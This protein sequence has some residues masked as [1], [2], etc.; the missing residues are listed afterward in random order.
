MSELLERDREIAAAAAVLEQGGLLVVDGGAGTGKTSL[1]DLV[2]RHA[3]ALGRAVVRARGSELESAFPFGVARQLFERPLDDLDPQTRELVTAGPAAPAELV[4]R[5]DPRSVDDDPAFAVLHGLYWLTVNLAARRPLVVVV[6]D[7]HWSDDG[8]L[9]WLAYLATRLGDPELTVAVALRPSEPAAHDVPLLAVRGAAS[10][11]IQPPLLSEAAVAR[12]LHGALGD[13]VTP[14]LAQTIHRASGGNPLYL[15]ELVRLLEDR[16]AIAPILGGEMLP[17]VV[18]E[19]VAAQVLARARRVD[20]DALRLAQA[21]A[22]LGDGTNIRDGAALA[23]IEVTRAHHLSG[24]L[25]R[26][27]LLVTDEPVRFRHPVVRE[28]V[29][30]SLTA[31]ERDDGHRAAA[32]LLHAQGARVALVAAHLMRARPVGDPWVVARLVDAAADALVRGAPDASATLLERARAE[33]PPPDQRVACLRALATAEQHLGRA[34][35]CDHL[36]EAIRLAPTA[37]ERSQLALQLARSYAGLFRWTDAVD[38]L[39]GALVE[40]DDG[41]DV[42]VAL[43]AELVASGLQDARTASRV[44]P[45]LIRMGARALE[46]APAEAHAVA[47]GLAAVHRGLPATEVAGPLLDA[48]AR[49]TSRPANWQA[50]AAL[51]WVLLVCDRYAEVA[52]ALEP[53]VAEARRSGSARALVT[54]HTTLG[55]LHLRL[56]ALPEAQSAAHTALEV[57]DASDFTAGLPFAAAVLADVALEAGDLEGADA[58]VE[59]MP[60]TVQAAGV[61][62]VLVPAVRGRLELARGRPADALVEFE[63]CGAL[64][65]SATWGVEMH[66]VGY[67]H[68][69][70]GAAVALARLGDTRAAIELADAEVA[71]VTAFGAARPLG[72]ALRTSG[73]VRPGL[74]GLDQLRRSADVLAG[75]PARLQLAHTLV[76]LGATLR[77]AGRRTES[78]EPLGDGLELAARYGASPLVRRAHEELA[79]SGA[80][81]RR[82]RRTGVDSLTPAERRVARLAADG[83]SNRQIAQELYVALKTVEG[84]LARVYAKLG[85]AGRPQLRDALG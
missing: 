72:V 36:A 50:R 37:R 40:V 82:D 79:L 28:A 22:V 13:A 60:A 48:L 59:R 57:I 62:G 35:G 75:S 20:P 3:A 41:D 81:P 11:V 52:A 74:D 18:H 44:H 8:S 69:R 30:A 25:I 43:E 56:G 64:W 54:T 29:E 33:P 19:G 76:E 67:L 63:R 27:D 23:G 4:V 2:T 58:M 7:A 55:L 47:A 32:R 77:R 5:G 73:L 1:L 51:L 68:W 84:H 65:S 17:V 15:H 14:V 61:A 49:A 46:G 38:V 6:D 42:A 53:M 9:R 80:R 26:L 85:V 78:R 39:E 71:D 16:A 21:L 83:L 70:T 31:A 10:A 45:V 34:A 12:V 24:D 66:D